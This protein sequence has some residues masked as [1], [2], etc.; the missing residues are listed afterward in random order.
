MPVGLPPRNDALEVLLSPIQLHPRFHS[1]FGDAV[2][3]TRRQLNEAALLHERQA[4]LH[5]CR[6]LRYLG[7]RLRQYQ[8]CSH[9][10]VEERERRNWSLAEE[11]R[12]YAPEVQLRQ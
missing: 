12:H 4:V 10:D 11:A 1:S 6:G 7:R 8:E 9:E 3:Y 2:E 5:R